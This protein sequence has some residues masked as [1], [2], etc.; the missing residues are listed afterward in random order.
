MELRLSGL[1]THPFHKL[2]GCHRKQK[3]K[4]RAYSFFEK[5]PKLALMLISMMHAVGNDKRRVQSSEIYHLLS[6]SD[7]CYSVSYLGWYSTHLSPKRCPL[8]HQLSGKMSQKK[9]WV[10]SRLWKTLIL[11]S[12]FCS[13]WLQMGGRQSQ[14]RAISSKQFRIRQADTERLIYLRF[15][16]FH[17]Q[18][19]PMAGSENVPIQNNTVFLC[20]N[21]VKSMAYVVSIDFS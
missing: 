18:I 21:F 5:W 2:L 9:T 14:W 20:L 15:L 12:I 1:V 6:L 8:E 16:R 7:L 11:R 13:F 4:N 17:N 19:L 10:E 3:T